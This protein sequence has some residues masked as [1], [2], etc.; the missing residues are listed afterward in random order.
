MYKLLAISA[1]MVWIAGAGCTSAVVVGE[2]PSGIDLSD[3]FEAN[4]LA[5]GKR[6]EGGG[7]FTPHFNV[8]RNGVAR[9]SMVLEAP[10]TIHAALGRLSGS[11]VLECMSTPVFNI[12]DGIQMD[13]F[14]AENGMRRLVFSRYFDA[15]RRIEDRAWIPLIIPLDPSG[16]SADADL[17]IRITGGPQGD[18][19]ADWF[20]LSLVRIVQRQRPQ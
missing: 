10:V 4:T 8:V 9:D 12:G 16:G 7:S 20:A 14:L 11:P 19:V 13:V 1:T 15:G 2:T 17:E 18:L 6:S 3:R 5:G